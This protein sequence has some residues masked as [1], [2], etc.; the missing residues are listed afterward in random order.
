MHLKLLKQVKTFFYALLPFS[1][2]V[3]VAVA[4]YSVHLSPDQAVL[5]QALVG[6]IALCSWSKHLTLT[7][8][9]TT[10]VY[11]W[12]RA[13]F[14]AGVNPAPGVSRDTPSRLMALKQEIR[15]GLMGH[16]ARLQT[17]PTYL[18]IYLNYWKRIVVLIQQ[19]RTA[20]NAGNC[21]QPPWI[22]EIS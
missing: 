13:N 7:V 2:V 9:D 4:S 6:D 18:H 17:L 12:V 1:V 10:Q 11:K 22:L 8:P 14:I 5:V 15:S 20:E 16:V 3:G 21:C 19:S